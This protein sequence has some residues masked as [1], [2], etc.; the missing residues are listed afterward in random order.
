MTGRFRQVV[1]VLGDGSVSGLTRKGDKAIDLRQLG[2]ADIERVSEIIFCKT[3]QKWRAKIINGPMAGHS[4]TV[5]DIRAAEQNS[6]VSLGL[7][8]ITSIKM[9]EDY[10][11]LFDDYDTAVKAEIMVLDYLRQAGIY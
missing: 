5:D 11:A 4:I 10:V 2:M 9:G 6:G 8:E 7:D 3:Q 1:S